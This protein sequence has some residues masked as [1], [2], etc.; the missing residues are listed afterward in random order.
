MSMARLSMY[1]KYDFK[2][3]NCYKPLHNDAGG[4]YTSSLDSKHPTYL[5]P[6]DMHGHHKPQILGE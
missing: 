3:Q 6:E 4:W 5:C 2:C 1:A